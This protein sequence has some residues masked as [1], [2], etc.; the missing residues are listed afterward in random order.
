VCLDA[1]TG[2]THWTADLTAD[3]SG[4]MPQW[5]YSSS[6][7]VIEGVVVVFRDATEHWYSIRSRRA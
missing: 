5:G 4:V 1:A 6:P 7:L 3:A 2:R